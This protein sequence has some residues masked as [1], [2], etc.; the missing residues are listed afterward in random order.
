MLADV[1]DTS[2]AGVLTRLLCACTPR[3]KE[4]L[5]VTVV[6]VE[7][8]QEQSVDYGKEQRH[9]STACTQT[10]R[11]RTFAL[12]DHAFEAEVAWSLR[13]L[14]IAYGFDDTRSR[15]RALR[16][17]AIAGWSSATWVA[18]GVPNGL[19]RASELAVAF[20][21]G[22]AMYVAAMKL[23]STHEEGAFK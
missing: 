6:A 5:S 17:A 21:R 22:R 14:S 16:H 8:S 20:E 19:A 12:I 13:R 23:Q 1:I 3:V 15:R 18:D 7:R 2:G 4:G 9:R 11:S 10:R